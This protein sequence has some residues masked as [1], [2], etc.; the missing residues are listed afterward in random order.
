M[1]LPIRSPERYPCVTDFHDQWARAGR[2][3]QWRRGR[4]LGAAFTEGLKQRAAKAEDE[5]MSHFHFQDWFSPGK[6][7]SFVRNLQ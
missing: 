5:P 2:H 6:S 7:I 4:G 1:A 3:Q